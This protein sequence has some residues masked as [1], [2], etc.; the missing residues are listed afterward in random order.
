MC[1]VFCGVCFLFQQKT[2]YEVRISCWSSDVCSSDLSH[3]RHQ[4]LLGFVT[5]LF[6]NPVHSCL[7]HRALGCTLL[8]YGFAPCLPSRLRCYATR[9]PMPPVREDCLGGS[10]SN[11]SAMSPRKLGRASCRERGCQYV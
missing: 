6:E 11:A 9:C 8:R 2:A 10:Q 7:W 5:L 1:Y 4:K 3:L